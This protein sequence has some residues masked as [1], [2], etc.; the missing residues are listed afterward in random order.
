M[1]E[2]KN[3]FIKPTTPLVSVIVPMYNAE[4]YIAQ[5]LSSLYRQT[6]KNFEVVVVDDCSTD[7]SVDMVKN[8]QPQIQDRLILKS[9]K[10][11]SGTPSIPR[12]TAIPL[13]Y[14]FS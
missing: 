3:T 13:I 9:M 7:N 10:E 11:N 4:K 8:F 6:F 1:K 12:N 14:N 2:S 5:C